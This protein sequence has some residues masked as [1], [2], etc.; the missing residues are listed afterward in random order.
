MIGLGARHERA[1][2]LLHPVALASI[3]VLLINDHV[4]K[5]RY[6]GWITGK[7]SDIAG[8][9]FFP[10]LLRALVAP[11]QRR[12]LLAGCIAATGL[13][14]TA[15]KL[16]QPATTLCEFVLGALQWPFG[17]LATGEF[18][19]I[20]PVDVVRDPTDLLALPALAITWWIGRGVVPRCVAPQ[21]TT[22]S[23]PRRIGA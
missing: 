14:F 8:L 11:W 4:L 22:P 17:V 1:S 13:G 12:D 19:P 23:G 6:P 9:V 16:W 18:A 20:T 5:S 21:Y 3:A 2:G 7:L 15:V 10:L